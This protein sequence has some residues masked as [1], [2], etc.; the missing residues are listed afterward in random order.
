MEGPTAGLH[1]GQG[2][3]DTEAQ[4][5]LFWKLNIDLGPKTW[6]NI[7]CK[8]LFIKFTYAD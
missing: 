8:S 6:G 3:T 1:Q 7:H 4:N 2:K 5:Q